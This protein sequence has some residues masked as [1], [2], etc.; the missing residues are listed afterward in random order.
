M[1]TE[2][3]VSIVTCLCKNQ[4]YFKQDYFLVKW[5]K[6]KTATLFPSMQCL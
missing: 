2:K 3:H 6:H 4:M 5:A 1:I